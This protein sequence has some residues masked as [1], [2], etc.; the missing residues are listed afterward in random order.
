[1]GLEAATYISDLVATNPAGGDPKSQGD[2]HIRLIKSAIKSTFPMIT[3]A[4]TATHSEI[5]KLAGAVITTAELNNLHGVTA[6][7]AELNLLD[8]AAI[9]TAELNFLSGVTSAVQTQ[10]NTKPSKAGDSYTG[11]HDFSGA[12]AVTLPAATSV[13]A[14]SAAEIFTL[15]GVMGN[16]QVQL[17]ALDLAK[18]NK[19]GASYSGVHDFSSATVHVATRPAGTSGDYPASV[20][21]VNAAVIAA[22][23][24]IPG[25]AGN[26]GKFLRT[27]GA[28]AGWSFVL[29]YETRA[30]GFSAAS[31]DAGKAFDCSSAFTISLP[32]AA[33]V[34]AS[35]YI[36]VKASNGAVTI[37]PN[38][39]ETINGAATATV[40]SG[41]QAL[42]ICTGT[43]FV[44]VWNSLS[45]LKALN[46]FGLESA[47]LSAVSACESIAEANNAGMSITFGT[48]AQNGLLFCLADAGSASSN[49]STSPDG[50]T[51]TLRTMPSSQQWVV[52]GVGSGFL[53]FSRSSSAVAYS[54]DGVTW[55]SATSLASTPTALDL[56]GSQVAAN[57]AVALICHSSTSGY[58]S[59][60]NGASWSA[61]TLPVAVPALMSCAGLFVAFSSGSNY[62]TSAT[63]ATGSWTSRALPG[64]CNQ[65]AESTDG[66]LVAWS[67]ADAEAASYVSS[68]GISW[69]ASGFSG[70][71]V[72]VGSTWV[73]S[74]GTTTLGATKTRHGGRWAVRR[75]DYGMPIVL[76]PGYKRLAVMSGVLV[77]T[78]SGSALC[79]V[80]KTT[81]AS[82]PVGIFWG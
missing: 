59:S 58:L 56:F 39:A 33:T 1:M 45:T 82:G 76:Q 81:D 75:L 41:G 35:W 51:W 32:A 17:N 46:I 2:N 48:I 71:A 63:G 70:P 9:T 8:G 23:T 47:S 13:G 61:A 69:G 38:G 68:D 62:Y 50:V 43:S 10:I 6:S 7:T 42:V 25:Q 31:G 29:S 64:A 4:V 11:I 52:L 22:A 53:A 60:N 73:Q 16:I 14:V 37:D 57:G 24:N 20:D 67:S 80:I 49:V 19:S 78:P 28:N 5:N 27:D 77:G 34:G 55:S 30:A 15:D 66:R 74:S 12:S 65:I 26:S 21:F 72:A 18:P 54:S 40:P 3:G 79:A 44:T 36:Y